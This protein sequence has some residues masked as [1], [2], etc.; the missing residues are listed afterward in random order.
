MNEKATPS[1]TLEEVVGFMENLFDEQ[2]PKG[3]LFESPS[4][5]K[6]IK[7]YRHFYKGMRVWLDHLILKQQLHRDAI[8]TDW[9]FYQPH[10]EISAAYLDLATGVHPRSLLA[11]SHFDSPL[12]MWGS[13]MVHD[14]QQAI[15]L[16]GLMGRP[17]VYS[18]SKVVNQ[19]LAVTK[20]F[21]TRELTANAP[22]FAGC[23]TS[24]HH[25]HE[26]P[27]LFLTALAADIAS[28]DLDFD[29]QYWMPYRDRVNL[30]RRK[31]RD[32][33]HLQGVYL[34]PGGDLFVTAKGRKVPAQF[35]GFGSG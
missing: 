15:A 7:T 23:H 35:K 30:W 12:H 33:K 13:L 32:C 4:E 19:N 8:L 11:G 1:I 10:A 25:W 27:V 28:K 14:C 17:L 21:D 3:I 22:H 2:L 26:E 6:L 29:E 31:V 24:I 20:K 18:K 9:R 16:S 5:Q 34:L